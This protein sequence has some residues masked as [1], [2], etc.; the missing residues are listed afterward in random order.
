M[1]ESKSLIELESGGYATEY[2]ALSALALEARKRGVS[3]GYLAA[4]TSGYEREE[5]IR[6]YCAEK[7]KKSRKHG[8]GH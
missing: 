1:K 3:Y 5:I 4:N 6:D 8:N 2:E 7:R